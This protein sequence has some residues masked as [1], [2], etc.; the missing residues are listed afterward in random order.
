[1][2]IVARNWGA[3]ARRDG[4]ARRGGRGMTIVARNW[5]PARAVTGVPGE[6]HAA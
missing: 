4:R 5:A 1:M 3:R 2:T 6:E